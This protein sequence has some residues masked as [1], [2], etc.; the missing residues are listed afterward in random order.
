[1]T[2]RYHRSQDDLPVFISL[3]TAIAILIGAAAVMWVWS[4]TK[5]NASVATVDSGLG[6]P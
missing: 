5:E 2:R 3:V 1:M 6:I 4:N